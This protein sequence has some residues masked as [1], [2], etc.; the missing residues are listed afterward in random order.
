LNSWLTV[1]SFASQD[2]IS[3]LVRYYNDF[4]ENAFSIFRHSRNDGEL[5][6]Q[7]LLESQAYEWLRE[8]DLEEVLEGNALVG[9][10]AV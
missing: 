1:S 2:F 9:A 7:I 4:Q 5:M 8:D 10:T 3:Q 6:A